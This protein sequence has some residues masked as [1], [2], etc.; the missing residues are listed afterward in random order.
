[1]VINLKKLSDFI[2]IDKHYLISKD[3]FVFSEK[4]NRKLKMYKDENGYL[5]ITLT[6]NGKIK[7]FRIHR[8]VA[9]AFI[10][11][12]QNKP[13]VNH[14]D[15]NKLNN[16]VSNLEWCTQSENEKHAY[17]KCNHSKV[18]QVAQIEKETNKLIAVY[19]SCYEAH[20]RTKV[21]RSTISAQINRN[22]FSKYYNFYFR[23]ATKEQI[24]MAKREGIYF[25]NEYTTQ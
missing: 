19:H 23:K 25:M 14:K 1:M 2:E 18:V 8:L 6:Y 3:G 21:K 5:N 20:R 16:H 24:E 9:M 7:H 10:D 17:S 11:N 15:G 22:N 12:K 4:T 13:Q